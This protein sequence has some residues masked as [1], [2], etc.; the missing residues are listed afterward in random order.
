[1]VV[2]FDGVADIFGVD[3]LT[4]R[5][6]ALAEI[7]I[8]IVM[9]IAVMVDMRAGIRK[10]RALKLP[11]DSHGLR[12]TFTK[13]GDYGKV[14]A[15]FMCIDVLGLLFGIWSMPYASAVSAVIAVCIEAWSVRENL[16]AARSSAAKIGDIVAELAHAKDPKDIIEL[17]RTLD[18]T[19]EESKKQPSK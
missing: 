12:R 3:I 4:V 17:L 14:T 1:M 2:M 18:R 13:F 8:W 5:R 15:L 11:I 6:A 16:R 7:I 19:R 9:F 10:A